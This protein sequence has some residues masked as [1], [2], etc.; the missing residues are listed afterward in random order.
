MA[1]VFFKDEKC[2]EIDWALTKEIDKK[3]GPISWATETCG[4]NKA[5]NM[6]LESAC[7]EDSVTF[8]G[9]EDKKC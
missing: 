5:L 1:R 8:W 3:F 6:S 9:F 2:K 7:T 4:W